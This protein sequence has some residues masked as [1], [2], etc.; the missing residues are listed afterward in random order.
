MVTTAIAVVVSDLA[1][2]LGVVGA[3]ANLAMCF[4]IPCVVFVRLVPG[5]TVEKVIGVVL[6]VVVSICSVI[7]L[8][9]QFGAI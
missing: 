4:I 7:S 3:T 2:V 8:L 9:Q 1:S 6:C 5:R